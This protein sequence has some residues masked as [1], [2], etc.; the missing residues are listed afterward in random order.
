MDDH[1]RESF[2]DS[3]VQ[4]LGALQTSLFEL[5][6]SGA[7]EQ[8]KR[9]SPYSSDDPEQPE[10]ERAAGEPERVLKMAIVRLRKQG[11]TIA[12]CGTDEA[13]KSSFWNALMGRA[14]LPSDGEFHD[15]SMPHHILS[16]TS[17]SPSTVLPC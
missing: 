8:L 1:G 10:F 14:I 15:P 17:E 12:F 6:W 11:I 5:L 3:Q 2:K 4:E 7:V 9:D 13:D 16:I